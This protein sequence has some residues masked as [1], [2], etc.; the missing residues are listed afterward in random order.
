MEAYN[1][2]IFE[3][4]TKWIKA[5]S[6]QHICSSNRTQSLK[7]ENKMSKTKFN[8]PNFHVQNPIV[9]INVFVAVKDRSSKSC[10]VILN[11]AYGEKV[12]CRNR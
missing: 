5:L 7:K 8:K 3:K 9:V 10:T 1:N 11:N 12:N 4:S 6:I 2:F